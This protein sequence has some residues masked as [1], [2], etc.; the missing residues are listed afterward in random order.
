[1]SELTSPASSKGGGLTHIARASLM[2]AFF[3]GIDK[4][5]G[6]IRQ[7][8]I[9]R[10][11]GLTY[12][13]DVFNAANNIPDLLSALISG[14]ALGV[15][16]IPVLSEFIQK[17]GRSA[18]WEV[19]SRTVNFAFVVTG[20]I[21]V[22][23]IAFAQPLVKYV[24]APGFPA[25]QQALTV[26]LMR[27]DL[28]AILVFSI[29]GLV[30]A[31][32]Q[33]NQHFLFPA[34]APALYNIGQIFGV[35]VLAPASQHIGPITL[36]GFGMGIF[37][38]VYGVILGALL[39][40][41]IQVP[42]LIRYKFH[43]TPAIGLSDPGLRQVL[44]LLGPRVATMFFLQLF[45]IAR[46]NIASRLGE[47]SVTALNYGWFIMQ[48]PE[49]L[50]GSALAIVMLPTLAE[51]FA[52]GEQQLFSET[53]N[54]AVRVILGLTIPAAAILAVGLEPVIP[55]VFGFSAEGSQLVLWVTRGYL[56]G[57]IGHSLLETAARSFYA[58]QDAR[59]PL[60]L[61]ALNA[62]V[63]IVAAVSLSK[64]LGAPGIAL[65][66]TFS[67]TLEASIL[68][69]LLRRRYPQVLRI[70]PTLF[71]A[72]LAAGLGGTAAFAVLKAPLSIHPLLLG[73][74]ALG[75]GGLVAL[76]FII[77]EIKTLVKL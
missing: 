41:A 18:A 53:V 31:G 55:A 62:G 72:L 74:L 13:I 60:Y 48:V 40:L 37:G 65:A 66:N 12:E 43:W 68:L 10:Q 26:E 50:I 42:G 45:F 36:P 15:A 17:R 46:D 76:P 52:R 27:I 73:M 6:F 20:A 33:A 34:M 14:G 22:L 44:G 16:L 35:L 19:F 2:V 5:L 58:Q 39:H 67:F 11:F 38:L 4:V 61:A 7:V 69:L 51:I 64:W 28:L 21:S 30:M 59:T 23:I 32:L 49:T 1:M 9:A 54:R 24:I 75:T 71:R 3:F 25:Q 57:L 8:L 56:L 47:G 77:P 29:S 70:G 63:Y